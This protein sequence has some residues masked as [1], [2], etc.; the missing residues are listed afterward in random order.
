MKQENK[1][2]IHAIILIITF[3]FGFLL[4]KTTLS[5]YEP[6]LMAGLFIILYLSKRFFIPKN[7]ASK[8][9]ESVVFALV[10]LWIVN[11]TGGINSSFFFLIYFLL[12]SLS[13]LLHPLIS[14]TTTITLII[15]FLATL[16]Q[17]QSFKQI[18]PIISLAFITPFAMFL[19]QEYLQ[20]EKLKNKNERMQ[21]DTFLFLSLILKNHLKSIQTLIENFL[22]DHQLTQIKT[23][24]KKMRGLIDEFEKK[25]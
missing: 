19:G 10:V 18:L 16:P 24:V 5:N 1:V 9:I 20:N 15:F 14:L 12:F 22:G 3:G 6:Q 4:P 2:L 7:I 23:H 8:L 25:F 17:N 11:T 21:E 13:L